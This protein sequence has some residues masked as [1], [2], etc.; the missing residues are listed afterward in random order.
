MEISLFSNHEPLFITNAISK[1]I[2]CI[3]KSLFSE[4]LFLSTLYSLK[5]L[6]T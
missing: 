4:E 3:T 2:F 1:N 5:E 6:T